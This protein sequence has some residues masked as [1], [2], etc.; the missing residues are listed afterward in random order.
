MVGHGSLII[1][2]SLSGVKVSIAFCFPPNFLYFFSHS[3]QSVTGD[4]SH[5]GAHGC[6]QVLLSGD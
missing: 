4:G 1:V 5:T 2:S 6:R 3:N